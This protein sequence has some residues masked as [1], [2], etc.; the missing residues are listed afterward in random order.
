MTILVPP[1]YSGNYVQAPGT[2]IGTLQGSVIAGAFGGATVPVAGTIVAGDPTNAALM[3]TAKTCTGSETH[4]AIWLLN[5]TAARPVAAGPGAGL[6]R[7]DDGRRR[8]SCSPRRRSSSASRP[9]PCLL[10]DQAPRGVSGRGEHPEHLLAVDFRSVPL[11]GDQ[12][13]VQVRSTT[14]GNL[15]GTVETPGDRRRTGGR[16]PHRQAPDQDAHGSS[17]SSTRTSSTH[18]PSRS[19]AGSRPVAS[20]SAEPTPTSWPER[21]PRSPP[22][23]RTT[24]VRSRRR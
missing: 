7:R 18:T 21:T 10:P 23:R 1:G 9:S 13:A 4:A 20:R 8:T 5:V 3:A 12:H 22:S 17:T 6:P 24:T 2:N 14:T 16:L 11:D 15:A 19:A